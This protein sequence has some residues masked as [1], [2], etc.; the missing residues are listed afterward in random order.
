MSTSFFCNSYTKLSAL[1]VSAASFCETSSQLC[2]HLSACAWTS[3]SL[4][5]NCCR[6]MQSCA[7]TSASSKC[8]M[9]SGPVFT[10]A[11]LVLGMAKVCNLDMLHLVAAPHCAM[12]FPLSTDKAEATASCAQV[13]N[14]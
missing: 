3:L 14:D 8:L 9:S 4:V 1:A 11:V 5:A 10:D 7:S 12:P 2:F 6:M 13:A